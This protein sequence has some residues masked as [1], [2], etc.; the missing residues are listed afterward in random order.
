MVLRG[1]R[2]RRRFTVRK[3]P[4]SGRYRVR[5]V[6]RTST[7]DRVVKRRRYRACVPR[8]RGKAR[9][10]SQPAVLFAAGVDPQDFLYYCR[11]L[12]A[13]AAKEASLGG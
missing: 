12:G 9:S 10:A 11:M 13:R 7:G 2:V 6:A 3:L 5:V 4:R 1:S 8:A